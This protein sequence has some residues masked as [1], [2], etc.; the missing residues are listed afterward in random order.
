MTIKILSL[1]IGGT[2]VYAIFATFDLF[3]YFYVFT[4]LY[5]LNRFLRKKN[6][7]PLI[8]GGLIGLLFIISY[9][10]SGSLTLSPYMLLMLAG[11]WIITS[12][13]SFKRR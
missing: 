13:K 12:P 7:A 11:L 6:W 9:V 3:G 5:T 1:F 8:R 10:F 4:A 2:T